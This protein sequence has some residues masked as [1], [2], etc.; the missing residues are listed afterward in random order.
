VPAI[1]LDHRPGIMGQAGDVEPLNQ[2]AG[3]LRLSLLRS[4]SSGPV[5]LGGNR[6]GT[7]RNH[8]PAYGAHQVARWGIFMRWL[9]DI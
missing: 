1:V 6:P 5:S 8:R 2:E 9:V 4:P 3:Y 7:S